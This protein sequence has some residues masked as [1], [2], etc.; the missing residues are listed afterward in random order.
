MRSEY[1]A[2]GADLQTQVRRFFVETGL[3]EEDLASFES[4]M[5]TD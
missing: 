4:I 1:G 5:L 2:D 3:T